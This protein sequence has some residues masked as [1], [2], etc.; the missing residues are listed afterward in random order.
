MYAHNI[1]PR[2]FTL[3]ELLI[4]VAIIGILAAIAIPNFLAA[5]IRAKVSRVKAEQNS[6]SVAMEQYMLDNNS[7]PGDQDNDP[8]HRTQRGLYRLTT[9][10]SY[11]SDLM[12]FQ[13][14]FSSRN[15]SGSGSGSETHAPFYE[16]GSGSDNVPAYRAQCYEISSIGPNGQDDIW[17]NDYFPYGTN[18]FVY[19]PTNGTV[20]Y[21]DLVRLGG[22]FRS[23]NWRIHGYPYTV[24]SFGSTLPE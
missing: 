20:S 24:W 18:F 1:S 5:Q 9:P 3:I 7:Y 14:Q 19:D 10:I 2:G 23:G 6:L 13:D 11:L 15:L 17:D 4:V 22:S 8:L 21:G 12:S 16:M